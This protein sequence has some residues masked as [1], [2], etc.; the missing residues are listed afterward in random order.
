MRVCRLR[1]ATGKKRHGL[2]PCWCQIMVMQTTTMTTTATTRTIT[3]TT[4]TRCQG[5]GVSELPL[6]GFAD[7]L[8]QLVP[9]S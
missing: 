5:S 4:N 3:T 1:S 9:S 2:E 8:L 6:T 7:P